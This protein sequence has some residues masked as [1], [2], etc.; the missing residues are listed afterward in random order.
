MKQKRSWAFR[1]WILSSALLK[2][3]L[4]YRGGWLMTSINGFKGDFK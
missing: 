4:C 1:S 2:I 3:K